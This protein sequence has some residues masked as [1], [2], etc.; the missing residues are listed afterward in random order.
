MKIAAIDQDLTAQ[1]EQDYIARLE[2]HINA[3]RRERTPEEDAE[4]VADKRAEYEADT[5]CGRLWSN[6]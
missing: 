6:W 4:W 2:A 1:S 5:I 3:P